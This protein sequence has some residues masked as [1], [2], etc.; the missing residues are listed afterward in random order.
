M[1]APVSSEVEV[2]LISPDQHDAVMR[3]FDLVAYADNPSWSKCYCIFP[4]RRDYE[5]R[6]REENRAERSGLIRSALANGLVAYRLGRVVGWCH[7]APSTDVVVVPDPS[8]ER[9]AIV[10][11]VVAP[12][13][14]RQG[15]ASVL[16]D[17]ALHHLRQ[18]GC[19]EVEAAP[20][21]PSAQDADHPNAN[22][23]GPFE[24]YRRA[25]FSVVR[26]IGRQVLVRRRLDE[27]VA[28]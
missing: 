14:R 3:F 15:V 4:L 27:V 12:D 21:A 5:S 20:L 16:L 22:Y 9:G 10:C 7:A 6:T 1:R 11:F 26:E 18:R 24:M 23:H 13:Q 8:P 28:R 19:R 25:G 2:R 17:H